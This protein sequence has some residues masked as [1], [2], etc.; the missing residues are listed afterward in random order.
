MP[1]LS[2][3]LLTGV[4]LTL[5][6][7]YPF[8]LLQQSA[9]TA[10]CL[11]R[12]VSAAAT[13]LGLKVSPLGRSSTAQPLLLTLDVEYLLSAAHGSNA[14]LPPLATYMRLSNLFV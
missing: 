4:S 3:Y 12:G 14:A 11:G 6:V 2:A 9:A 13:D 7:G 8:R 5:G 1:C 10:H